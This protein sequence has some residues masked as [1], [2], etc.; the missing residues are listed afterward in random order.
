MAS[1][2]WVPELTWDNFS[3]PVCINHSVILDEN[4]S[5][6]AHEN[7]VVTIGPAVAI[8]PVEEENTDGV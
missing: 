7:C 2:S 3:L 5:Q 1:P 8:S 4:S 6:E